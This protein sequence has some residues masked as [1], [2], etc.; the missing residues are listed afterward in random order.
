MHSET[1]TKGFTLVELLVAIALTGTITAGLLAVFFSFIQHQVSTQEQRDALATVRFVLADI[2]RE[3]LFATDYSCN[4]AAQG[5]TAVEDSENNVIARRCS[6]LTFTDQLNRRIKFRHNESNNTV[7]KSIANLNENPTRCAAP[8]DVTDV[9]VWVPLSDTSVEV[10]DLTFVVETRTTTQNRITIS[11]EAEYE[12]EGQTE[13]FSI[14]TQVTGRILRPSQTLARQFQIG[15]DVGVINQ[16]HHFLFGEDADGLVVCRDAEQ[17]RYDSSVCEQPHIPVAAEFTEAGLY[18]LTDTGLVFYVPQATLTE[19]L[20]VTG[21]LSG[22]P[23]IYVTAADL[24]PSVERVVGKST[25]GSCRFCQN[26][27]RGIASLYPER[28]GSDDYLYALGHDGA[29]YGTSGDS[30]ESDRFRMTRHL[31]GG[32]RLSTIKQLSSDGERSLLLFNDSN[33]IRKLRLYRTAGR[34]FSATDFTTSLCT[35]FQYV[36]SRRCRQVWPDPV[37][38]TTVIEPEV[39]RTALS[40][41]SLSFIDSLQVING[42]IHLWYTDEVGRHLISVGAA[43]RSAKRSLSGT[44]EE[45][46]DGR[47]VTGGP[48]VYG[49]GRASYTFPCDKSNNASEENSALCRVSTPFVANQS[50]FPSADLLALP[51]D[52][53]EQHVHFEGEAIGVSGRGRL[54]YLLFDSSRSEKVYEVQVY[55]P[56]GSSVTPTNP[57]RILC[58][59]QT[60]N[61]GTG[62]GATVNQQ[63]SFVHISAPHPT[64]DMVALVGRTFDSQESA[65]ASAVSEVYLLVPSTRSQHAAYSLLVETD[66]VCGDPHVERH[67]LPSGAGLPAFDL[68]RLGGLVFK[69][70]R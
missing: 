17:R 35:E 69:D 42:T 65:A 38:D 52:R 44:N 49:S 51:D 8:N 6:C 63:V 29:L 57:Q 40:A 33:S 2:Q 25:T 20:T 48:F 41:I 10:T 56:P 64:E 14:Q 55:H 46:I 19:A 37:Q 18:V 23:P 28:S 12:H 62:D 68:I 31:V 27:P 7:E 21:T 22:R 13:T 70:T 16:Y 50:S 4:T 45:S 58:G 47:L 54:L 39:L 66:R 61:D 26:D 34:P 15:E 5:S 11:F 24:Q 9:D 3:L 36:T 43:G 53:L 60:F 67:H 1:Q 30:R 59:A 32:V